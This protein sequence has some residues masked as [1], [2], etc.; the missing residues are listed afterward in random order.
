MRKMALD[1]GDRRIGIAFSDVMGII[2]SGYETFTRTND[3]EKDMDYIV[4]LI[5]EKQ[6]DTVVLGLPINMDGTFG[7]RAQ[8]SKDYG[9]KLKSRINVKV[10]YLD[11]RLTTVSAEK[12]LISADVRRDKRKTV[13]DKIA[14]TIILQ[15]Y[16]DI[17]SR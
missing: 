7:P 1:L 15:D 4:S 9:E 6:V 5:K 13:I 10:D 16:L 3:S 12:L 14:A 8:L 11:E 2:A 17:H